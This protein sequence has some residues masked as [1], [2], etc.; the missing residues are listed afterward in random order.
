MVQ[1]LSTQT[2]RE[3]QVYLGCV[4]IASRSIVEREREKTRDHEREEKSVKIGEKILN[5][6]CSFVCRQEGASISSCQ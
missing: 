3:G 2:G 6:V 5:K 1:Q 4:W